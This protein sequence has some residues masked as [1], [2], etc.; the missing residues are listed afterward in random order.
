MDWT[1]FIRREVEAQSYEISVHADDERLAEELTLAEVEAV[2]IRLELLEDYPKDPRGPSCLAVGATS[3]GT[4]VHVVCG[5]N[6]AGHLVLITV[7]IPRMPKW[8][9]PRTRNR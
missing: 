7:Y 1:N 6:Q 4:P 3:A 5:R 9:D 8:R 2:L